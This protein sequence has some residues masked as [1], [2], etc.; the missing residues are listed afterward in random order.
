MIPLLCIGSVNADYVYRVPHLPAPGET[1][2]AKGLT[3]MLGGKGANQSVA[4]ALA[5][6]QV[7]HV[8]AVGAADGWM[9]DAME[10]TGVQINAIANVDGP[11]GHAII[12]VDDSGE[13]NIILI[14]GAN[15]QLTESQILGSLKSDPGYVMIQNETNLCA[16]AVKTAQKAG[17]KVIYSAAPFYVHAV[18]EIAPFAD[19]VLLNEV[20]ASQWQTETGRTVSEIGAGRVIV[21]KGSKGCTLITAQG[22]LDFD[23][24]NVK[25]VD[26]TGA[27]DT[28]AGVYAQGISAGM[29]LKAAIQRAQI[30]AAIQVTRPG[31]TDAMPTAEEIDSFSG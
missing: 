21:T 9:L 30:A 28:F 29:T 13:N 3:R 24:P 12:A 31:T 22:E 20:E 10:N 11:S 15:H 2:S 27:G 17:W 19:T 6:G 7:Q 23:A 5:G 26:T 8:G 16:F 25:A 4:A 18:A 14:A 1:L